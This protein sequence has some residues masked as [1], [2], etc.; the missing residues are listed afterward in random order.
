[1]PTLTALKGDGPKVASTLLVAAGD[2]PE[3]LANE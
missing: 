1:V 3:R 2:N